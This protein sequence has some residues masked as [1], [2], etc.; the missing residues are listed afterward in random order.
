MVDLVSKLPQCQATMILRDEL[1]H[2]DYDMLDDILLPLDQHYT[3]NFADER[4]FD[5]KKIHAYG[6]LSDDQILVRKTL[7]TAK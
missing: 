1:T 6:A 7:A 5:S 2:C 3:V 4:I